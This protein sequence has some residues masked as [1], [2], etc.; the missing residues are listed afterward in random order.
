[1]K[2]VLLVIDVQKFFINRFTKDIPQ[3]I[4]EFINKNHFDCILFTKFVND[5]N[6]N[7]YKAGWK[8]MMNTK[9]TEL[10]PELQ[11][12]S[13]KENTFTKTS[14]SIFRIKEIRQI[15]EEKSIE[16]LFICGLDTHACIYATT[17]EAYEQGY[18]VKVIQDLCAASHG[19]KYHT[20]ALDFLAKNLGKE[21]LIFSNS[22][23]FNKV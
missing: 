4:A 19:K 17:L 23:Y 20:E 16:K 14:F 15:L 13:R 5:K 10:V 8:R 9:D 22:N 2:S 6:S 3:K 7:W 21:I 18:N 11:K 12:Y 1:M